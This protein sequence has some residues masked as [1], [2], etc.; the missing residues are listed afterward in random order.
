MSVLF[1][2]NSCCYNEKH[3]NVVFPSGKV[4]YLK[5]TEQAHKAGHQELHQM[6]AENESKEE[7]LLAE[8]DNKSNQIQELKAQLAELL[9]RIAD[10]EVRNASLICVFSGIQRQLSRM[11]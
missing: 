9:N 11:R 2:K 3:L 7:S 8:I 4:Q 10:L 1:V 6:L 5:E